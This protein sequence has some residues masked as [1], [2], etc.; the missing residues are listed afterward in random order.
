MY[1]QLNLLAIQPIKPVLPFSDVLAA[2][3]SVEKN[4]KCLSKY[5]LHLQSENPY[6]LEFFS[7]DESITYECGTCIGNL[8]LN[9]GTISASTTERCCQSDLCNNQTIIVN[10][11]AFTIKGCASES[12][13]QNPDL[14]KDYGVQTQ[15]E[16]YC[17]RESGCNRGISE[18][19]SAQTATPSNILTA[20]FYS[21]AVW[22]S[23]ENMTNSVTAVYYRSTEQTLAVT[24]VNSLSNSTL[25][26]FSCEDP[27][28]ICL[29]Q[30]VCN[31]TGNMSCRTILGKL[32]LSGVTQTVVVRECGTCVGNLS[33][34]GGS[35]SASVTERC[36]QSA[37]CNNPSIT[38]RT[39]Q[40]RMF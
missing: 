30:Q 15:Q 22:N 35:F 10:S 2:L 13:C 12:M 18:N 20:N 9:G 36:C 28:G 27:E 4:G 21:S 31:A 8:S 37:L 16:F 5:S 25:S 23:P 29:E 39:E 7:S 19:S 38:V 33:F 17:C 3:L 34:N 26:C 24:P 1:K 14:L 40:P 32:S 11:L 6:S